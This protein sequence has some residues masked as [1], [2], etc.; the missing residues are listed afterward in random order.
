MFLLSPPR[1]VDLLVLLT[2]RNL[3]GGADIAVSP[4]ILV[5]LLICCSA[6]NTNKAFSTTPSTTGIPEAH[7]G[8]AERDKIEAGGRIG[9]TPKLA[10][11]YAKKKANGDIGAA[12]HGTHCIGGAQAN[13][14]RGETDTDGGSGHLDRTKNGHEVEHRAAGTDSAKA[15]CKD[16]NAAHENVARNRMGD[17]EGSDQQLDAFRSQAPEGARDGSSSG[18]RRV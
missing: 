10:S 18:I 13:D 12:H 6:R 2:E 14:G 16:N 4:S 11:K 7:G 1:R 9:D 5:A 17:D 8:S 15:M 3:K